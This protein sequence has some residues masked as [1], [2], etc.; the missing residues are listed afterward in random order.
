MSTT[1]TLSSGAEKLDAWTR[2]SQINIDIGLAGQQPGHVNS[3][4][5][6]DKIE[7]TVTISVEH[8]TRFDEIEIVFEGM[9]PMERVE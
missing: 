8:E 4:T 7:G 9:T 5:T 2:R 1:S 6:A 3:Y